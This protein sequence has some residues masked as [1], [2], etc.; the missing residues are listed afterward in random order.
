MTRFRFP[1][2]GFLAVLFLVCC[3]SFSTEISAERSKNGAVVKIDGQLFTEY[4]TQSGN[5]PILWPILGPTGKPMTRDYPMR[6]HGDETK[7]HPHHRSLWFTHGEVNGVNFWLDQGNVGQI[8]HL[9]FTKVAGGKPATIAA[10][11][12]WLAPDGKKIGEDDLTLHFDTDGRARWIDFDITIHATD[13]PMRFGDTKEGTFGV[14]VADSMRVDAKRGGRIVNSQGQTDGD[15]WGKPASWVDYHGPIDGQVVGIAIFNHPGSFRYPTYWHVRTYGL[16]AAN[17]FGL[18][19]FTG[20]KKANGAYE[21][22]AGKSMTLRYRI[23]FHRG[24]E[25]EGKV[26]EAFA[27]YSRLEK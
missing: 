12:A 14:R 16:F 8:K 6:S 3:E 19:D 7:D 18:H 23:F 13:G 27:S 9:E 21:L 11:H 15:A 1:A 25:R 22:P 2:L 4:W 17:P 26:A 10:R 5:K 24:D 20:D